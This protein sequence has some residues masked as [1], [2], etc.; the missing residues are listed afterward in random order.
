MRKIK[1]VCVG[2]LKENFFVEALNEYKKRIGKY[3][4][5]EIIELPE[6][7]PADKINEKEIERIKET[8]GVNILHNL[9]GYCVSLCINGKQRDSVD[10]SDYIIEKCNYNSCITFVIGGSYGLSDEV[11]KVCNDKISFS[12]MTFPHQLMRV[13]LLEQIYRA[14]T[15]DAGATYH[16]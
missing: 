11:I 4:D 1:I 10:F 15:I 14:G 2:N 8:E 5:L 12:M 6:T 3:F 7:K 13:I 9:S 16:K